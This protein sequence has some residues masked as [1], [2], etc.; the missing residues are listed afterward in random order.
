MLHEVSRRVLQL[1]LKFFRQILIPILV[2][3]NQPSN[4]LNEVYIRRIISNI[5][6]LL[7]RLLLI[8]L[9]K[10]IFAVKAIFNAEHA[11][12]HVLMGCSCA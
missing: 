10:V 2:E 8:K 7:D 1:S 9:S 3:I 11:Q 6:Q 12:V 4:Q 5:L